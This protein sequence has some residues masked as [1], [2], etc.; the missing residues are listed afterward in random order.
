MVH[1]TPVGISVMGSADSANEFVSLFCGF[2][3][4]NYI[5]IRYPEEN[6]KDCLLNRGFGKR[7]R[8]LFCGFTNNNYTFFRLPGEK[9]NRLFIGQWVSGENI[10]T[11]N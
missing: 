8:S 11:T 10:S 2:T 4:N 9:N 3:N 1:R 6:K 7:I 5:P